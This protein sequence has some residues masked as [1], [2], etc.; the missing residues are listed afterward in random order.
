MIG[1]SIIGTGHMGNFAGGGGWG[2][3]IGATVNLAS[4]I[5]Q[6]VMAANQQNQ[7]IAAQ[8]EMNEKNAALQR[9]FAQYGIRWRMD[10]ARAAGIHPLAALGM[11]G[12]SASPSYQSAGAA[13]DPSAGILN[14]VSDFGQDISRSLHQTRTQQERSEAFANLKLENGALQNDLLR[15]QI[16]RINQ[17]TGPGL[18][19]NSG[20]GSL[21]SSGQGDGVNEKYLV[22]SQ[23]QH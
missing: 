4:G 17:Q 5:A 13:G 2:Q 20:L 1:D 22:Q 9:E 12:A 6:S 18:P 15:S 11:T 10:D 3:A 8:N 16:A 7:A 23:R 19:S 21:T 14:A